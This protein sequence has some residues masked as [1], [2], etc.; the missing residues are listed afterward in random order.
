MQA[1]LFVHF[2]EKTTPDGEQV[3]FGL[4]KDGFHWEEVNGGNPV[5]WT[6]YGEKGVRDFTIT[7][8]EGSGRFILFATDSEPF[9]WYEKPVSRLLGGNREKRQQMLFR[10]GIGQSGGLDGAAAGKNRG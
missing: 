9:L 5:L 6:Y 10:M 8:C 2:K 4:S 3:Y 7:R 1:Y